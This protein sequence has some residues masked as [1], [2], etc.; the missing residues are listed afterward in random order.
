MKLA[1]ILAFILFPTS[2]LG[3]SNCGLREIIVTNLGEKYNEALRT[4]MLGQ[5]GEV[6]EVWVN[7]ESNSFT[8]L[9]NVPGG[10]TCVMASG[11]YY[12]EMNKDLQPT[13]ERL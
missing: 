7:D 9:M 2:L 11:T 5:K 10:P 12:E 13:G 4:V 1:L 3:Q 6:Y 8:I